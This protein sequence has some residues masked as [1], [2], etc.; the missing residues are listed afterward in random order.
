MYAYQQALSLANFNYGAAISFALGG[1]VFVCVY[2]FMFLTRKRG[3][4]F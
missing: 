1:V 4:F 2:V 3:S